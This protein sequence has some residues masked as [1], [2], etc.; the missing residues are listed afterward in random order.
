MKHSHTH[1]TH[2]NTVSQTTREALSHTYH[3]QQYSVTDHP[4]SNLT[5]RSLTAIQCHRPHMKH[6]HSQI[7]HSNTVSQTTHEA[8]THTH[9]THS[10]TV[11]Q[12]THEALSLTDHS[13]QYSVTAQQYSVTDHPWS[14]LTHRSLTAMQY[15][16]PPMKQSVLSYGLPFM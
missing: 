13:Q 9:I 3:S 4:W 6:S 10:N 12:T 1:I 14:T 15:H 16:R 5:H 2:S 8:L 7:T 11:S